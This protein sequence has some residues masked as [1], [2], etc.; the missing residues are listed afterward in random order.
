MSNQKIQ[1]YLFQRIREK[2]PPGQSLADTVSALLCIS[3]DSAYR[4]IRGETLLV[5]EE[6]SVLCRELNLSLDYLLQITENTVVF[7]NR[8]RAVPN[9][10]FKTFLKGVLYD[11]KQLQ[12]AGEKS[13]IYVSKDLPV[14][15]AFGQKAT[16][17]FQYFTWMRNVFQHPDFLREPF[18]VNC[19]P[20][21]VEALQQEL[22][23]LYCKIPS[24]EIWSTETINSLL[25]ALHHGVYTRLL[26]SNDRQAVAAALQ[27]SLEHLQAQAAYGRKFL[28]GE[29]PRSKKENFQLFHNRMGLP[30]NTILT[31][32]DGRKTV[33][34]NYEALSYIDTSDEA[35]CNSVYEQLQDRMRR[36]TLISS[37][38]EKQRNIFFNLLYAKLAQHVNNK[39]QPS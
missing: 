17:S 18:S 7:R 36:S 6:A 28:P 11:L 14:F 4:R 2:L 29:D 38:G 9:H 10:N 15:Y 25:Q 34:L 16:A 32:H 8:E 39:K 26:T 30:N 27:Q 35:F 20:P 22:L 1:D 33:Y 13:L 37:V 24:I 19:L 21:D 23:A 31:L 12:A 3:Q 5:L